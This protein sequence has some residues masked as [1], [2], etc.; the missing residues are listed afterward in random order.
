MSKS[1]KF[2]EVDML[3]YKIELLEKRLDILEKSRD[4]ETEFI[5]TIL[6]TVIKAQS[7]NNTA[8]STTPVSSLV[9]SHLEHQQTHVSAQCTTDKHE[10]HKK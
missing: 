2:N 5:N 1:G 7:N 10:V 9:H 6:S 4:R 8:V 3:N